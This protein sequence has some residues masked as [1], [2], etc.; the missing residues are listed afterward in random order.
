MRF[1]AYFGNELK[2]RT[3]ID[4]FLAFLFCNFCILCLTLVK[5]RLTFPKLLFL[6][7]V[8]Q[9]FVLLYC[10]APSLHALLCM[11]PVS[12]VGSTLGS[13]GIKFLWRWRKEKNL[14]IH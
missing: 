1:L 5:P 11:L 3:K 2:R 8:G 12:L 14:P 4:L 10:N 7:L 9:V 13:G 6:P